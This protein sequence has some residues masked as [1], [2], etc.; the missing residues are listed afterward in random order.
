[1]HVRADQRGHHGLASEINPRTNLNNQA[2]SLPVVFDGTTASLRW[3]ENLGA[4]WQLLAQ[5]MSQQLRT[6]DRI[7]FPFGCGAEGNYDRYC[8]DGSFDLYDYRS[9]GERRD[10]LSGAIT[11]TGQAL[12]GGM[13]H[14]L[15][16]GL[17][18][19]DFRMGSN[20][21][22][23][24]FAGVGQIDGS[25]QVGPN[26]D[27]PYPTAARHERSAELHLRDR[28]DLGPDTRLW[29]GVRHTRLSRSSDDSASYDQSF[30]TPWVALSQQLTDATL[31]YGSWGQGVETEVTPN[32]PMYANANRPLPAL[33]S[34]Q[35]ELGLKINQADWAAGVTLF[36]IRRPTTEDIGTCDGSDGSCTRR[37]DGNARHRGIEANAEARWNDWT[38]QASA[39]WLRARREGATDATMNGLTPTN[40]AQRSAR[41]LATWQVPSFAGLGLQASVSHEGSRY[42]LPDDSAR[43]PGW[44]TMGLA[45][46]Y[47]TRAFGHDCLLRLGVDNLFDRRAWKESPYEF[48]HV[49]LYPLE[50]RTY[51]ASLQV[52]L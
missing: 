22:V 50:P 36:D 8:S 31:V 25:V 37:I 15:S 9:E 51:R 49:Y 47:A 3:T 39:Q 21:Q 20:T 4:D 33:K 6:D 13:T 35:V 12:L 34:E 44:T 10:T 18:W 26:T 38:L 29:L 24:N 1:M 7:A 17:G 19:T 48:S 42:V 28:I 5:A 30:T 27:S 46:R 40:V 23:Y 52:T 41:V 2:W 14:Q 16:T 43:I 11:L 45:S 32:L